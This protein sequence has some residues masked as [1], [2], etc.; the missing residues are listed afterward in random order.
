MTNIPNLEELESKTLQILQAE[1]RPLISLRNLLRHLND[2]KT[3]AT[4]DE[5]ALSEFIDDH[6]LFCLTRPA[7]DAP[8]FVEP[9]VYLNTRVP[10]DYEMKAHMAV[11]LDNMMKA[12]E[13]AQKEAAA[14]N[15]SDRAQQIATL[16]ERANRLRDS[17]KD[18]S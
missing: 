15:D 13:A 1:K 5:K 18:A 14:N 7:E 2:I 10:S 3:F 9:A 16:L 8:D 17:M 12:L 11:E 4:L 6:E